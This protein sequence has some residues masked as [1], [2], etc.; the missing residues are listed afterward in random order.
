MDTSSISKYLCN[1]GDKQGKGEKLFRYIF[2]GPR[3]PMKGRRDE[4]NGSD[5]EKRISK[6]RNNGQ[7]EKRRRGE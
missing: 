2:V 1:V 6:G 4:K 5:K 3:V 7:K